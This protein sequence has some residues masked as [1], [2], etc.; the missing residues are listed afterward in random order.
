[1]NMEVG[2]R[3]EDGEG[4]SLRLPEIPP[5]PF[6]PAF[7][8][9]LRQPPEAH[10][11]TFHAASSPVFVFSRSLQILD[12]NDNSET[13]HMSYT[14]FILRGQKNIYSVWTSQLARLYI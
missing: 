5:T 13:V 1:M 4:E 6:Y 3:E 2:G 11:H 9:V 14:Y 12:S 7:P 8:S 10:N